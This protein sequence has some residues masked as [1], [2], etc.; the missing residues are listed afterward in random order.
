[1]SQKQLHCFFTIRGHNVHGTH[2]VTLFGSEKTVFIHHLEVLA[3]R[4][5]SDVNVHII[6]NF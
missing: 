2:G 4:E 5:T 3:N 6:R 1:M